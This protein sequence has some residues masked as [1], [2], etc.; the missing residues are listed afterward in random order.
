MMHE[1]ECVYIEGL[2]TRFSVT[3]SA[4]FKPH[5]RDLSIRTF[6]RAFY[7]AFRA[8]LAALLLHHSV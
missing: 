4:L 3:T 7:F 6:H 8:S 5:A 2:L 1:Q